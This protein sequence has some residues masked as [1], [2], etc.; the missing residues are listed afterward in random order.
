MLSNW[1]LVDYVL[2]IEVILMIALLTYV[3][4]RPTP[5]CTLSFEIHKGINFDQPYPTYRHCGAGSN[6]PILVEPQK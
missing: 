2:S 1:K 3:V 5:P 4:L 6:Y